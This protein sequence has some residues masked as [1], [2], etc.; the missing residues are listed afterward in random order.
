MMIPV[1]LSQL[2]AVA[3][4]RPAGYMEEV[5]AVGQVRGGMVYFAPNDYATLR[6]K[7]KPK[8][9]PPSFLQKAKNFAR[10]AVNH[11]ASGMPQA[12]DEEIERRFAICQ[13]CEFYK[14]SSCTKCGC[15]ISRD[16]KFVSKL[17]WADQSCPVGKWGNGK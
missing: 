9:D 4:D 17:A 11:V 10:A 5:L 6:Q 13:G 3:K 12:S 14:D 16:R 8:V 15:P 1:R 7:Y 2:Q